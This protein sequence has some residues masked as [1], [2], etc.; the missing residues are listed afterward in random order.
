MRATCAFEGDIGGKQAALQQVEKEGEDLQLL[1]G[2]RRFDG[3]SSTD[4]HSYK[5]L[6][7]PTAQLNGVAFGEGG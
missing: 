2:V 5:F 6:F 3:R 7:K 4:S 1:E